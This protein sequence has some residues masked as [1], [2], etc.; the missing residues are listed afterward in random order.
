MESFKLS[1]EE[2]GEEPKETLATVFKKHPIITIVL[3]L[4]IAITFGSMGGDVATDVAQNTQP[5]T[6]AVAQRDVVVT[7]QNVK[8]VDGKY[9]YFF[10]IRNHDT[11]PFTGDVRIELLRADGSVSGREDFSSK[12]AMVSGMGDNVFID[13]NSGPEPYF[14]R[15]FA[16]TGF[17]YSVT[18]N[19]QMIAS[20]NGSLN[21]PSDIE[22]Y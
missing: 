5:P 19:N 4:I 12:Q 7:S 14:A 15:E 2:K 10:D 3:I 8:Q 22:R 18:S 11:V 1:S 21:A 20:G 6:V 9:R 16:I 17:R 13:I